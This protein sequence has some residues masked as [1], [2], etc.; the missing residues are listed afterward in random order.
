MEYVNPKS[1]SDRQQRSNVIQIHVCV[2]QIKILNFP[3]D[4][5]KY[6]RL[7]WIV[8]NLSDMFVHKYNIKLSC[9]SSNLIAR[10]LSLFC[11]E[12]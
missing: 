11:Y 7:G 5:V 6:F 1:L 9:H 12:I 4:L 8:H 2:K 3:I 10:Y